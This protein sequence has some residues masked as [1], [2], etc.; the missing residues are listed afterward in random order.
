MISWLYGV[1]YMWATLRAKRVLMALALCLLPSL[2]A[3]LIGWRVF[4]SFYPYAPAAE[5][6]KAFLFVQ[7]GTAFVGLGT[8]IAAR[9]FGY[10]L[11][12]HARSRPA[13]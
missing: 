3:T 5:L 11:I 13:E 10:R 12:T 9:L 1:P 8:G 7:G 4:L 2:A 6:L